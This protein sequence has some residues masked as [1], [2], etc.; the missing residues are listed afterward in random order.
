MAEEGEGGDG[1]DVPTDTALACKDDSFP[2][3]VA[4]KV[5]VNSEKSSIN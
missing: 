3:R 4:A 5:G 2:A 1:D